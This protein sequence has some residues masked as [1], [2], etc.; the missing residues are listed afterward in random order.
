M[1][2]PVRCV[3]AILPLLMVGLFLHAA[4]ISA[5]PATP[6]AAVDHCQAEPGTWTP[7]PMGSGMMQTPGAMGPGMMQTPSPMGPGMMEDGH[8][9][10]A[11]MLLANDRSDEAFAQAA[12]P[13]VVRPELQQ[14]AQDIAQART[15]EGTQLQTWRER[16][17]PGVAMQPWDQMLTMMAGMM[18]PIMQGSPWPGMGQM[19]GMMSSPLAALCA[20][21]GPVDELFVDSLRTRD[22]MV[23]TMVEMMQPS[24]TDSDIQRI[25]Q[26]VVT[27]RQWELAQLQA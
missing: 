7:W 1:K 17:Y 26:D 3:A 27:S 6:Q 16:E 8:L 21:T 22:Q 10:V 4:P 9:M 15:A 12:I 5:Q 24:V 14:L 18:G 11:T 2:T 20:A 25:L 23:L 19:S 13:R